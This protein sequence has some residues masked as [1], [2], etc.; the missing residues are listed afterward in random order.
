MYT[1]SCRSNYILLSPGMRHIVTVSASVSNATKD[2]IRIPLEIRKCLHP[3]ET[4]GL[5][6]FK[7]YSKSACLV[8]C[9]L[10]K[11]YNI[12]GCLPWNYLHF[13]QPDSGAG[14]TELCDMEGN[15]C[16]EKVMEKFEN[17]LSCSC[18]PSCVEI[19]YTHT[20]ISSPLEGKSFCQGAK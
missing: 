12:C 18:W 17:D 7:T 15:H 4:S 20:L 6:L 5:Q 1:F 13:N 19:S 11:A 10:K 9:N 8:E 2:T 14:I 16:V 3:E